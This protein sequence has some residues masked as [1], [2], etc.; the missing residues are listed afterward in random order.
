M[1]VSGV[2]D[3]MAAPLS[4]QKIMYIKH[5]S[6]RDGKPKFQFAVPDTEVDGQ[7][8]F[9]DDPDYEVEKFGPNGLL[10]KEDTDG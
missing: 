9:E 7:L 5:D 2:G 10:V 6:N 3:A 8:T 1:S 4:S